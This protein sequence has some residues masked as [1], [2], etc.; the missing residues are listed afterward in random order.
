MGTTQNIQLTNI[1]NNQK[2][3][4]AVYNSNNAILASLVQAFVI[5]KDLTAPPGGETEGDAYIVGG[6]A[7][8]AWSGHDD[9][10]AVYHNSAWIFRTPEEGWFVFVRDENKYY[11]FDGAAWGL[12]S[13]FVGAAA[14][15]IEDADGDTYVETEA[16]ADEDIVRCVA[17]GIE[18]MKIGENGTVSFLSPHADQ[19]QSGILATYFGGETTLIMNTDALSGAAM[20]LSQNAYLDAFGN[21]KYLVTDKASQYRC[22]NGT[23]IFR[24][25]VSGTAD[26]VI[27][28]ADA[29]VIDNSGRMGVGGLPNASALMDLQSTTLGFGLP[30]MTTVQINAISTPREGLQVWDTDIKKSKIYNGSVW[31]IQLDGSA[32]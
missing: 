3:I 10:I 14:T 4:K 31:R 13:G 9:D 29:V 19:S 7:T 21:W 5:D 22:L 27:S 30:A 26:N 28:W 15:K 12:F 2:N 24:T 18:Y 11:T 25:A 16:S 8:G 23:H 1:E 17:G 20:Q 32:S 6:S